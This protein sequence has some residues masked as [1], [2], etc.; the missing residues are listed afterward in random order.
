MEIYDRDRYFTFTGRH[1]SKTPNALI[2][3]AD[4]VNALYS[5]V[6]ASKTSRSLS[7]SIGSTEEEQLFSDLAGQTFERILT[8][9]MF[10]VADPTF[11]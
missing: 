4:A 9:V 5:R 6:A 1:L 3:R 10:L 7:V 2:D 11:L 8:T